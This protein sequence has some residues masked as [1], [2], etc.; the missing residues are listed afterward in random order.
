VQQAHFIDGHD[1]RLE[2]GDRLTVEQ[3]AGD[4]EF[5]QQGLLL[6][7]RGNGIAAP[8]L[9]PTGLANAMRGVRFH[10]PL[11]MQFQRCADQPVQRGCPRPETRAG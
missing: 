8:R 10:D 4:A 1:A 5:S 9:Q 11:P 6:L 2:R 7:R 3:F